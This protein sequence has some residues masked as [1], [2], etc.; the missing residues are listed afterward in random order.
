MNDAVPIRDAAT[1][2]LVR[3]AAT[4]PAILMGQ[5]GRGAIFM[6]NK[7]VF[8]GGAVDQ[9]DALI[10]PAL[11]LNATCAER[12][13]AHSDGATPRT[14]AIAAIR[15]LWEETGLVLGQTGTWIDPPADWTGFA[16]SGHVPDASSLHYFFRA[17]TPPGRPRR[18]DA[19][20]FLASADRLAS[21][22]D[23]MADAT[24]ELSHLAWVPLADVRALDLAFITKL[25]LAELENHLPRVDAPERVPFIK[26][27]A[28]DSQVIW[29]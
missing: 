11:D 23:R 16:A 14:L 8:P 26:N 28:L 9:G 1:I 24:E 27:D 29:I 18:F 2:I 21:D 7:F 12:L 17:V 25:V 22:P 3:D 10:H 4:A 13:Q 15:E 6:P 5:R 19:R 20:F